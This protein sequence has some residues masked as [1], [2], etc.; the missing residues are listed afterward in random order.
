MF[1]KCFFSYGDLTRLHL[2]VWENKYFSM[3]AANHT[4]K[5]IFP[6]GRVK[7]TARKKSDFHVR[8]LISP[9]H[10][11]KIKIIKSKNPNPNPRSRCCRH[12]RH[13]RIYRHPHPLPP[14]P[15]PP[16]VGRAAPLPT[17]S[18]LSSVAVEAAD[19]A[20]VAAAVAEDRRGTAPPK[21]GTAMAPR[22]PCCPAIFETVQALFSHC[23]PLFHY[24]LSD[25]GPSYEQY[26]TVF[27]Q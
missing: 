2:G 23:L 18:L 5:Y 4:K 19:P 1:K 6:C 15:W 27:K 21:N 17:A 7:W 25:D 16:H 12:R 3:R 14:D 10:K 24:C 13:R 9:A 26:K 8:M 22:A 20:I 11:I